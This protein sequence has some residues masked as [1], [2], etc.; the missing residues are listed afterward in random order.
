MCALLC[1]QCSKV[2]IRLSVKIADY[3]FQ[4]SITDYRFTDIFLYLMQFSASSHTGTQANKDR[5]NW[6]QTYRLCQTAR[7]RWFMLTQRLTVESAPL[8]SP[9]RRSRERERR[10]G[11]E[12]RT[13]RPAWITKT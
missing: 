8:P 5:S 1:A 7:S 9:G 2:V 3:R 12:V 13:G 4:F 10:G 6:T 11:E